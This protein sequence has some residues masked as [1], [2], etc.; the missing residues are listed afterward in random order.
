[1]IEDYF[2]NIVAK[3]WIG[4]KSIQNFNM[5]TSQIED[6]FLALSFPEKEIFI[7]KTKDFYFIVDGIQEDDFKYGSLFL[8]TDLKK[9]I[10]GYKDRHLFNA[11]TNIDLFVNNLELHSKLSKKLIDNNVKIKKLKI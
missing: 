4:D 11:D 10:L 2:Q 7:G 8:N 3:V 5:V 1:M 6:V 9:L